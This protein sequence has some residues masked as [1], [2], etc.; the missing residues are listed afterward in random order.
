MFADCDKSL[1]PS[2]ESSGHPA[3][4]FCGNA[5]AFEFKE[6]HEG[7]TGGHFLVVLGCDSPGIHINSLEDRLDRDDV[8]EVRRAVQRCCK[9]GEA[10]F[11][12]SL[13]SDDGEKRRYTFSCK[14]LGDTEPR[15]IGLGFDGIDPL[16]E[17]DTLRESE[18]NYREIFNATGDAILIHDAVTGKIADVNQA[19]L[20]AWRM[21]RD[22]AIHLTVVDLSEGDSKTVQREASRW[23]RKAVEEGPQ[24]FEWSAR[25]S[26][27][28]SFWVEVSLR[29]TQ[30]GGKGRLLA[31]ARDI[32]ER[33]RAN[34]Q[35]RQLQSELAHA[36]R[37]NLLG[38]LAS[39]LAHELNQ[40]LICLNMYAQACYRLMASED[41][42]LSNLREPLVD[43][44][45]EVARATAIVRR[46][47]TFGRKRP[48]H[49]SQIDINHLVREVVVLVE[50]ETRHKDIRLRFNLAEGL[51]SVPADPVQ[52]QQV[53]LNLILNG[54][55]AIDEGE[56]DVREIAVE[57]SAAAEG[58]VNVH[59]RDSGPGLSPATLERV[60]E[61][62]YTTKQEGM[63]LGLS[64]S[65]TI[66][67]DHDGRMS[68]VSTSGRGGEFTFTLPNHPV[69]SQND[70]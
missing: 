13:L 68:A 70:E 16:P 62:F 65:R 58:G 41:V 21:T 59:V 20:E 29:S 9:F 5:V 60:F 34:E 63:G 47:R 61:P 4:S 64:L 24:L 42:D 54:I 26:D 36:G 15:L 52:I 17:G 44:S 55:Q 66:I 45:K 25:R 48:M 27:G 37:L 51:P 1:M 30:I 49:R 53:I 3:P 57:T 10:R 43:I 2:G 50:H 56:S 40:P 31:V 6:L 12:A 46:L 8:E 18:S 35:L 39:G 28:T 32:S 67:E 33:R 38:E 7:R 14:S 69:E 23:M 11:E 22:E 19:A